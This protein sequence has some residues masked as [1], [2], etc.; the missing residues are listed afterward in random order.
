LLPFTL[1]A[2]GLLAG[3]IALGEPF[4]KLLLARLGPTVWGMSLVSFWFWVLMLYC[5]L[6][7]ILPVWL[8]L[9]PRDYLSTW[10]LYLGLGGGFLG[11]VV[12]DP[13]IHG[14]AWVGFHSAT[15]GPLWPMLFVM[16]ACGAASGFH[17]LVAG[18]TT[19]KQLRKETDGQ[20][21][22]YGAMILE[23]ALAG[24]VVLIAAGALP[25][26]PLAKPTAG[27]LQHLMGQ[28]GGPIVAFATGLSRILEPLP[29]LTAPMG[30]FFGMLMLNAF[31]ITT[32][33][34]STR[35]AR[36][37]WQELA[38]RI[39]GLSNRFIATLVTV[40]C[41]GMLG[42]SDSWNAIWPVFG[43]TNQLVAALALIVV[44]S[45]LVGLGK[46]RLHTLLPALFM[47]VTS[48]G[49]LIYQ[50]A[51]FLRGGQHLLAAISLGLIVLAGF[52]AWEARQLLL[53]R[54]GVAARQ[55]SG[56]MVTSGR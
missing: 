36:F 23:A 5:V 42:A 35:L 11:I 22:G 40:L 14:P 41:A 56:A 54:S 20:R 50:G 38:G 1:V 12:A 48:V 8:L 55:D 39:P 15:E 2:L 10:I 33:D 37:L 30:L 29:L 44:S 9:Q 3:L 34:T 7:S 19:S 32:L 24:L 49:A 46:P 43:A 47:L 53:V 31:V 21:I 27:S 16:I 52:I 25:W 18:G 45:W 26:D 4:A 6:A 28:G 13:A 51:G 17:S